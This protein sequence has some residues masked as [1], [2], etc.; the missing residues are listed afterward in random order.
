MENSVKKFILATIFAF[1]AFFSFI[2]I[3]TYNADVNKI[4]GLWTA[5]GIVFAIASI[6]VFAITY[7]KHK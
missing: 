5:S 1:I 2:Q 4:N 3:G 7:K 6:G